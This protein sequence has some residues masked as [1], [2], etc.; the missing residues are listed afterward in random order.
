M[1]NKKKVILWDSSL[2]NK[3][4]AYKG[5]PDHIL[6]QVA[7][8]HLSLL[9]QAQDEDEDNIEVIDISKHPNVKKEDLTNRDDIILYDYTSHSTS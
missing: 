1:S 2:V 4:N 8:I 3:P 6:T 7:Y 9:L 5:S